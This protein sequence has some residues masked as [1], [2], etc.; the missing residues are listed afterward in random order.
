ME[1]VGDYMNNIIDNLRLEKLIEKKRDELIN[2]VKSKNNIDDNV[3]KTS[4]ELD[5]LLNIF[6]KTQK[7]K[8]A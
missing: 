2:L 8:L 3:V 1:G 5:T 4:Q 7:D 6:I